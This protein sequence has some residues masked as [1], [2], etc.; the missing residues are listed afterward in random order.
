MKPVLKIG[1][2]PIIDHLILGITKRHDASYFTNFKLETVLF[3]NWEAM[4]QA[5]MAK[6]IHGTFI[7]FPLAIELFRQ[8]A[9]IK[10]VLLGQRE[11]QVLVVSPKI[12]SL[13]E[14]K[15]KAIFIPHK[16]SVHHIL[17]HRILKDAG[18]DLETDVTFRTGFKHIREI[19]Q[20]LKD[21]KVDAFVVA[22]PWGTIASIDK[23]L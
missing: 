20:N 3:Q 10:V 12:K 11:G 5:L 6:E 21:G 14:L 1:H 18:I 19:P 22:E 13:K 9:N 17:I 7:L 23:T 16:Y 4:T 8:G 2:F 15:N